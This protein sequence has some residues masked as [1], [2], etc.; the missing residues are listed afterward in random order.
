MTHKLS[1]I[2]SILT[3]D[4][5]KTPYQPPRHKFRERVL[6]EL[7]VLKILSVMAQMFTTNTKRKIQDSEH[8]FEFQRLQSVTNTVET[9]FL[10]TTEHGRLIKYI[11]KEIY[12]AKSYK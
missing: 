12:I 3:L 9:E 5:K 8:V 10:T 7:K 2:I 1:C 4:L 11:L 6:Q